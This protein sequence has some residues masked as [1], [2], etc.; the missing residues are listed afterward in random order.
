MSRSP[1][2]RWLSLKWKAVLLGIGL[3]LLLLPVLAAPVALLV[4]W[5]I[6]VAHRVDGRIPALAYG[7]V[8]ALVY[9]AGLVLAFMRVEIEFSQRN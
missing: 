6:E 7:A 5:L 9:A 1:R 3:N 4:T 2:R 8:W